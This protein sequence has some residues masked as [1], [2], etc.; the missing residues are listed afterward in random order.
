MGLVKDYWC[1]LNCLNHLLLLLSFFLLGFIN[2][3]NSWR[4]L[5]ANF[6]INL[7][8]FLVS[9]NTDI[10]S[11]I[12]VLDSRWLS[13]LDFWTFI[14]IFI[15]RFWDIVSL[16]LN[17]LMLSY[18]NCSFLIVLTSDINILWLWFFTFLNSVDL[19]RKVVR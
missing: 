2:F 1:G 7:N 5:R 13:I 9:V 19:A 17:A 11:N 12:K 14:R 4:S 6:F 10:L 8:L 16:N 18:L 15:V 3:I